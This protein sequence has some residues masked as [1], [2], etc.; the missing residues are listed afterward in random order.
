MRTPRR[1]RQTWR[2]SPSSWGFP[3]AERLN[4]RAIAVWSSVKP[5]HPYVAQGLDALAEV[6][7]IE[8]R[9]EGARGL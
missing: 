9:L 4:R 5:D 3:E 2:R 8:G 1:S 7:A 6:L